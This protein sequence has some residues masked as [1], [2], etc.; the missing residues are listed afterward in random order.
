MFEAKMTPKTQLGK[1]GDWVYTPNDF[2]LNLVVG[3]STAEDPFYYIPIHQVHDYAE[4]YSW[5]RQLSGKNLKLYGYNVVYDLVDAFDDILHVGRKEKL[6]KPNQQSW[7]GAELAHI[8]SKHLRKHKTGKFSKALRIHIL[9]RDKYTCQLCGAKAPEVRLHIDHKT[10]KSKGGL[11]TESN[12][13]V[14]CEDCNL[15]KSDKILQLPH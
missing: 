3:N 4:V 5:I 7:N 15:G 2:Y 14:L 1:W 10:P 8:Y 12:L 11:S 6:I 13:W 9:N